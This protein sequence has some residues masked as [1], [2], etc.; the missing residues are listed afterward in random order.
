[1]PN[2]SVHPAANGGSP[3]RTR[4]RKSR[5]WRLTMAQGSSSPIKSPTKEALHNEFYCRTA[6][7]NHE[8]GTQVK[9]SSIKQVIPGNFVDPN[10]IPN[11]LDYEYERRVGDPRLGGRGC[12]LNDDMCLGCNHDGCSDTCSSK[13]SSHVS[14]DVADVESNICDTPDCR[15]PVQDEGGS[16]RHHF[17]DKVIEEVDSNNMN[18]NTDTVDKCDSDNGNSQSGSP[19]KDE[20]SPKARRP[21]RPKRLRS[22]GE[23]PDESPKKVTLV[24]G[25][26]CG[27]DDVLAEQAN[28]DCNVNNSNAPT[29]SRSRVSGTSSSNFLQLKI[30]YSSCM[31]M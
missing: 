6:A 4:S 26:S 23:A 24:N 8:D 16:P 5:K 2:G 19:K 15:S 9:P 10:E 31:Y 29:R 1:M 14:A 27:S 11:D 25:D 7:I 12:N 30:K 21:S 13:R 22:S 20:K 28:Q 17:Q 18:G 3:A